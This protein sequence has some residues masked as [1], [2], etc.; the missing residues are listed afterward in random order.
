MP[1]SARVAPLPAGAG[2][3]VRLAPFAQALKAELAR[4][5]PAVAIFYERRGY[6]PIWVHGWGLSPDA[7]AVVQAVSQA[8]ADGFDPDA[9]GAQALPGLIAAA[10]G[11]R[12]ADL[13][14]AEAALSQAAAGYLSDL[15]TARPGAGIVYADAA[16]APPAADPGAVLRRIARGP[17]PAAA[18]AE[19]RRMNPL[20]EHLRTAL[21]AWKAE[22][23]SAA[24]ARQIRA[25]IERARGLPADLGE[26]Y[27]L[28]DAAAQTLWL[29]DHGR[30]VDSMPVVVGKDS[31]PTPVMAGL[32]R[33]AVVR[34]YWNVP[35]DLV[36]DGIAPKVLRYGAAWL[37][38]QNMEALSDWSEDARVLSPDEVDW[39]AVASGQQM[40]RVR[41]RPGPHN[42]MGRVKFMF[43]NRLGVYLHDT[44]L[45]Q[46]FAEKTRTESSGCV[47]LADAP[48]LAR[49]LMGP[50]AD[51]VGRPGAP[52]TR[53]DLSRPVPVYI[54][55]FTAAPT[56]HGLSF[57]RDIY[58]RDAPLEASLAPAAADA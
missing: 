46:Y 17:S 8:S 25:N 51:L 56:E 7:Q 14:R 29:Y 12:L 3:S 1:M 6:R 58:H 15:H 53:V 35:P 34:P 54:L 48:K 57:R 32:V 43:P 11:G 13:A 4:G 5:D 23:G 28:V 36:R 19:L 52:E 44:P 55:Y 18:V 39:A 38:S 42:M 45:R 9:Y 31:E 50:K 10:R 33:F 24:V 20:Y 49:W 41:Q 16:V 22:D 2:A 26:R 47:R 40:L 27:I 37:D 21:A 30:A